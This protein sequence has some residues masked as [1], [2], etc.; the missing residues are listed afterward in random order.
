MSTPTMVFKSTGSHHRVQFLLMIA[1]R[2]IGGR[3]SFSASRSG[4]NNSFSEL[5]G[6][7]ACRVHAE[8]RRPTAHNDIGERS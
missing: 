8:R 5:A 4:D 3:E 6:S 1:R 7:A 2:F